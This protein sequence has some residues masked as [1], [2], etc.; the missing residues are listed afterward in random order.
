MK[1]TV[2]LGALAIG[3]TGLALVSPPDASADK[4]KV[5]EFYGT[6]FRAVDVTSAQQ[7]LSDCGD[8]DSTTNVVHISN[9]GTV[10]YTGFMEGTGHVLTGT[11][12]NACVSGQTHFGIRVL[13]TFDRLTVAGRTGGAV[14]E[15]IGSGRVPATG[16][17]INDNTVRILC[18]TGEL[19]GIHAEGTLTASIRAESSG[20]PRIDYRP[21]QLW[22]H[23][24]HR[25]DVGFDFLC[26]DLPGDDSDD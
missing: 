18:G 8:A 25:H 10:T 1:T 7:N 15:I 21:M 4:A 19:K 16:I 23:F 24:G 17:Q 5:E 20:V 26:Q 13:D 3:L 9:T 11:I 14:V 12:S 2:F 6:G 22:V